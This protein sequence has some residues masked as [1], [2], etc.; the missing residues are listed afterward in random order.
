MLKSENFRASQRVSTSQSRRNPVLSHVA[1][2]QKLTAAA[3]PSQRIMAEV[4]SAVTDVT[5]CV[6]RKSEKAATDWIAF[7]DAGIRMAI[8][9]LLDA[10]RHLL[11]RAVAGR[12]ASVLL[13][14]FAFDY[15]PWRCGWSTPYS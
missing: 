13:P 9:G 15:G 12:S 3:C 5:A 8:E 7:P 14:L 4:P 10:E 11:G 6:G 2:T 1:K